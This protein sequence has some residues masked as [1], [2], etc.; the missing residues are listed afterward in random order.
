MPSGQPARASRSRR[1]RGSARLRLTFLYAGL[2]LA[3]GTV[4]LAATYALVARSSP[5]HGTVVSATPQAHVHLS[6]PLAPA[7]PSSPGTV[8][9]K[10]VSRARIK[11]F[12]S[13]LG[14]IVTAQHS[15]DLSR[16]L[17]VSWFVLALT[18]LV[19]ALL[20]WIAA[21]RVL[22]PVRT[23][24]QTARTISAG[25]LHERLALAGPDDEFKALGDTLDELLARLEASFESQRRFAANASHELR[26]PLTLERTLLQVVLADPGAGTTKLRATC[27]ELLAANVEQ[28]RLLEALLT[29]AAGERGLDRHEPLDLSA[30]TEQA[31]AV[32]RSELDRLGLE[33]NAELNPAP[34]I[35]DGDLIDRL[36]AN[37][38]E[39]ATRYNTPEG[40]IAARTYTQDGRATVSIANSGPIIPEDQLARLLEP[41]QRLDASRTAPS[42]RGSSGGHYGLGLSIVAAIAAAHDAAVELRCNPEGG[43][44]VT[45]RFAADLPAASEK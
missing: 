5:V 17:A 43:L 34:T 41:F 39:N 15:A 8:S 4:L 45:V 13:A 16:L 11:N 29:L 12:P 44:T 28:E 7:P 30:L 24:T 25:N 36:I 14:Y 3:L 2:F 23:I 35:G 19:S 10:P 38:I 21:G 18:T 33:L 31:L 9:V 40:Q 42:D 22:R 26:T 6:G 32:R 37:L 27:E 20:G 1:R